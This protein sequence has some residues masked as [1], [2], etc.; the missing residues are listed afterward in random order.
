MGQCEDRSRMAIETRHA[1]ERTE[2]TVLAMFCL[3]DQP[4]GFVTSMDDFIAKGN[5]L[6]RGGVVWS[7]NGSEIGVQT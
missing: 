7:M 5:V 3:R 1:S 6:A 4:R 2:G